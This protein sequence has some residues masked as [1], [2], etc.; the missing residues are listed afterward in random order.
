MG[1]GLRLRAH[2]PA[3]PASL[4][5]AE[6]G[7]AAGWAGSPAEVKAFLRTQLGDEP[8]VSRDT[9]LLLLL[10]PSGESILL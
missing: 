6:E 1:V 7:E 3:L 9:L 10:R 2:L 8:P 4:V 5:V